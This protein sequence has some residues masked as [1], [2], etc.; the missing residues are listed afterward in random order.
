MLN[1]ETCDSSVS[2]A[3]C[4]SCVRGGSRPSVATM[5][6]LESIGHAEERIMAAWTRIGLAEVDRQNK[7]NGFVEGRLRPFLDDYIRLQESEEMA[8]A[9]ENDQLF[10]EM[11]FS[12]LRLKERPRSKE[13]AQLVEAVLSQGAVNNTAVTAGEEPEEQRHCTGIAAD[14]GE[15]YVDGEAKERDASATLPSFV[16]VVAALLARGDGGVGSRSASLASRAREDGSHAQH[17]RQNRSLSMPMPEGTTTDDAAWVAFWQLARSMTHQELHRNL[18]TEV[19]RM[20]ALADTRLQQLCLL[21]KQRALLRL[22]PQE[23]ARIRGK[24]AEKLLFEEL[25]YKHS[26]K[27]Q[28]PTSTTPTAGCSR[29]S[30]DNCDRG[31]MT[32]GPSSSRATTCRSCHS[33]AKDELD[34]LSDTLPEPLRADHECPKL[35]GTDKDEASIAELQEEN[36]GRGTIFDVDL[37]DV[38]RFGRRQDLSLARIDAEAQEIYEEINVQNVRMAAQAEKELQCVEELWRLFE[39]G[40]DVVQDGLA[41]TRGQPVESHPD[42]ERILPSRQEFACRLMQLR[43]EYDG[44]E[45]VAERS[46]AV[47]VDETC[48]RRTGPIYGITAAGNNSSNNAANSNVTLPVLR[49]AYTARAQVCS[50]YFA[51]IS[52]TTHSSTAAVAAGVRGT[53][54]QLPSPL[55][56]LFTTR[57]YA[58][59]LSFI[60]TVREELQRRLLQCHVQFAQ[61]VTSQLTDLYRCYFEK[62]R[63]TAYYVAPD[64]SQWLQENVELVVEK[65]YRPLTHCG[66]ESSGGGGVWQ[67]FLAEFTPL[68]G[69]DKLCERIAEVRHVVNRASAEANLLRRRLRILDEAEPLLRRR[70]EILEQQ[71]AIQEGSRDRLLSKRINMAKQLLFEENA[72]RQFAR[73]LPKIYGQL[74]ELLNQWNETMDA[75]EGHHASSTSSSPTV[76][77]LVLHGTDI[78]DLVRQFHD[79]VARTHGGR[80]GRSPPPSRKEGTGFLT[81]QRTPRAAGPTTHSHPHS[82]DTHVEQ[83]RAA[84]STSPAPRPVAKTLSAQSTPARAKLHAAKKSANPASSVSPAPVKRKPVITR[85]QGIR[86][87]PSV[88]EFLQRQPQS[89]PR[90]CTSSRN[91]PTSLSPRVD[92]STKK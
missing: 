38:T 92:T 64:Y 66:N 67:Q 69:N 41:F 31:L 55:M 62:T 8:I 82:H 18:E 46:G 68:D 81:P 1:R 74:E 29:S 71:Q 48:D 49:S 33:V 53:T 32:P 90:R 77:R 89:A 78:A 37:G 16:S 9:A 59:V 3:S 40:A 56:K 30:S 57:S 12:S 42:G 28:Q 80:V 61:N 50:S 27:L 43:L 84:L 22:S 24:Y 70:S 10:R 88:N 51:N 4:R 72:R 86:S 54:N 60:V 26:R 6:L 23:Q 19:E 17:D 5:E 63:D 21:Y 75:D 45:G 39:E 35:C 52:E 15:P 25:H 7:W 47:A 11:F 20:N 79:D 13:L 2:L 76:R 91:K 85:R 36:T 14:G 44:Q 83:R 58:P 34:L 87:V 65:R 73:E